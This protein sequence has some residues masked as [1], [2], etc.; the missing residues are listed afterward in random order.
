MFHF[1][2]IHVPGTHHG[3]DGLSRSKPQ[4][5]DEPEK[6][7]DFEDWVDQV[8]GFIHFID[9]LP[10]QIFSLTN[11]PPISCYITDSDREDSPEPEDAP[12]P[13]DQDDSTPYSIVPRSDAA[14]AI[15]DKVIKVKKWL[16]TL[17]RPDSMTNSEYK[18]FMRYCTEFFILNG[19]LWRKDSKGHQDRKSVV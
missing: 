4:P 13:K 11:S 6:D 2:L 12:H 1:T 5:G 8:N 17:E 3:P 14:E 19:Q 7:D 16:E 18:S 9:P 15:D 10:F